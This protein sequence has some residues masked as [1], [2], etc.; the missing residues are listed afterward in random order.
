ML[1]L[2]K[3][4]NINVNIQLADPV[5]TGERKWTLANLGKQH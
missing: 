1:L 2:F 5:A 4:L 3:F